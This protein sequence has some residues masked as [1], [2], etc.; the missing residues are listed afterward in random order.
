MKP[1]VQ[2]QR[3]QALILIVL[4]IVGMVGLTGLA[5]DGGNAYSD[6][7]HAQN[8]ADTAALAAAL[9]IIHNQT[10]WQQAGL[11][12]AQANGYAAPDSTV[13]VYK[14]DNPAGQPPC[15]LGP[16]VTDPQNFVQ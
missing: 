13:N 12:Q 7:R 9:R 16:G 5:I 1:S 11:I 3:G 6:R 10:D 15:V 14:C 4:A 8:A 2:R